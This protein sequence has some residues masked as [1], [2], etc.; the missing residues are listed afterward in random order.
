[1]QRES[2]SSVLMHKKLLKTIFVVFKFRVIFIS[3]LVSVKIASLVSLLITML[4]NL[5]S[6]IQYTG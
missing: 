5:L 1:M 6:F 3:H 2:S 4:K